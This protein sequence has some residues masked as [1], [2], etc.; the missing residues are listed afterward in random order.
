MK[1][2]GIIC[3]YNPFHT[4]HSY[5]IAET[6]RILGGDC[7]VVC[8][9]SG[10]F[11]QRGDLAVFEK[12][13]RARC[14]VLSGADLVIELPVTASL[15]SAEGFARGGAALLDSLGVCTHLS[16]GS[17]SG[18]IDGIRAVADC[19]GSSET[20]ELIVAELGR[21]IP[22][23]SARQRAAVAVMGKAARLL[24]DPNDNLGLE[25]VRALSAIGSGM[26]PLAVRR[27]GAGHD[28]VGSAGGFVSATQIRRVLA[29]GGDAFAFMPEP[30]SEVLK[31]EISIGRGPVFLSDCET[32]VLAVLRKADRGFFASLPDASEGL[33]MR[34]MKYAGSEPT[35][36]AVLN[37]TKTKRYA[38]SR[39][40]RMVLCAYLGVTAEDCALPPQYVKVLAFNERGRELLKRIKRTCPLPVITKPAKAKELDGHAGRL[41]ELE[42]AA[43]DLYSLA[44]PR[45]EMRRG[46][47]EYRVSP[48]YV[49]S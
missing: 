45:P 44:Y 40:R 35:L 31:N 20:D 13:A 26:E 32:A 5:H 38:M 1:T 4:A 27:V 24:E 14:A 25:Y 29:E 17:E 49:I 39:I 3:E 48:E 2:A 33:D 37:A 9:M 46:G 22:Y 12:H 23:A 28:S 16:F 34:L 8:A 19:L 7:A 15:S 18:D 36:E 10:N 47:Q 43:T 11:V 30:C 41:F 6:R 21:G 42:T